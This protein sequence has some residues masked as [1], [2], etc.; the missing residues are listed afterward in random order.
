[1]PSVCT[2][3]LHLVPLLSLNIR[4]SELLVASS[5]VDSTVPEKIP[6]VSVTLSA[7]VPSL[8]KVMDSVPDDASTMILLLVSSVNSTLSVPLTTY[9]FKLSML[10][11]LLLMAPVTVPAPPV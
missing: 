2:C 7:A 4:L 11:M 8:C 6:S 9:A 1:M 5:P 10:V 3:I